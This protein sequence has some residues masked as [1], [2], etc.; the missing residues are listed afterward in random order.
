VKLTDTSSDWD[1]LLA[2]M[3]GVGGPADAAAPGGPAP[4]GPDTY[5]P[6]TETEGVPAQPAGQMRASGRW[7]AREQRSRSWR[8]DG[9]GAGP[10]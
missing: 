6:D 7:R 8:L 9:R 10:P 2:W 3:R 1:L 4:E 5:G